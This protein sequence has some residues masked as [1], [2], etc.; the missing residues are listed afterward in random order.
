MNMESF[1]AVGECLIQSVA[2]LLKT[3]CK[4]GNVVNNVNKTRLCSG[5]VRHL[6][7]KEICFQMAEI[8]E[9]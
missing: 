4:G 1:R 7:R 9:N 2:R 6:S 3:F 8:K 5:E